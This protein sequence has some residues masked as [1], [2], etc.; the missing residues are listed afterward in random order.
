MKKSWII[1]CVNGDEFMMNGK[2]GVVKNDEAL[3]GGPVA[4]QPVVDHGTVLFA[5]VLGRTLSGRPLISTRRLFRRLAW[6]R[7]RQVLFSAFC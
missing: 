7:V 1:C 3:S 6:H 2:M 5:E 4:G